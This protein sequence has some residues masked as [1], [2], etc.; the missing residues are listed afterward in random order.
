MIFLREPNLIFIKSR[1]TAGTSLEIALSMSAK[2]GDIVTP[3]VLPDEVLR[4]QQGGPL[5]MN[6]AKSAK[7]EQAYNDELARWV[8]QDIA[9]LQREK[10]P[11]HFKQARKFFNHMKP[12]QARNRLGKEVFDAA[13]K[14]C[15]VRDPYEKLVSQAWFR[16]DRQG[17]TYE[18]AL[19]WILYPNGETDHPR[20]G[21]PNSDFFFVRDKMVID[22]IIRYEALE[23]GLIDLE[24]KTGLQI[25][26]YMPRA[27]GNIRV[28]RTP[29]RE[30]LNEAQRRRCFE[31]SRWEF[32]YFGYESG[33]E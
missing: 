26:K 17:Q 33:F 2:E 1:K 4:R 16:A 10:L 25:R 19:E 28:D 30:I 8:D 24:R 14:V 5:P 18:E 31:L 12:E 9:D 20:A 3:L 11:P 29:A 15:V 13:T 7:V 6:W 23:A 22:T 21:L 32:E 27:K